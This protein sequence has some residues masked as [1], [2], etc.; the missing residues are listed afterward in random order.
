MGQCFDKLA[1]NRIWKQSSE[2]HSNVSKASNDMEKTKEDIMKEI[3]RKE[4]V[5]RQINEKRKKN[6]GKLSTTDKSKAVTLVREMS[7]LRQRLSSYDSSV[8]YIRGQA[9]LV[10]RSAVVA[11]TRLVTLDTQQYLKSTRQVLKRQV[12]ATEDDQEVT[13][14]AVAD[15]DSFDSALNSSSGGGLSNISSTGISD[16]DADL[17]TE[18]FNQLDMDDVGVFIIDDHSST[19]TTL[20]DMDDNSSV[21]LTD[22]KKEKKEKEKEK[23]EEEE[24]ENA[25]DNSY[26]DLFLN[27]GTTI[28]QQQQQQHGKR[29]KQKQQLNTTTISD[30]Q[31]LLVGTA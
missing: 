14:D 15:L 5:L 19:D 13:E 7:A 9:D 25:T 11:K 12:A 20:T 24:E 23:E 22:G 30:V 26:N 31:Q 3:Q 8:K 2:I 29:T 4:F 16:E 1:L 21:E 6:K 18:A 28:K 10:S 17:V 27:S